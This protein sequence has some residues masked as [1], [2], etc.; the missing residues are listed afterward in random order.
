MSNSTITGFDGATAFR[1]WKL[2]RLVHPRHR[3][4]S[5]NG[6]TAFRRWKPG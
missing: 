6:A 3:R 5:F 1:R 4:I 2:R